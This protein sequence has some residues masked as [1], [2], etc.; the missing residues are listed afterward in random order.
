MAKRLLNISLSEKS[1]K[2]LRELQK[3]NAAER[4]KRMKPA[5]D[6]L[7][8]RVAGKI[9]QNNL[10]GQ[11]L[12]VRSG[13][14]RQSILGISFFGKTGLPGIEVGILKGPQVP[15]LAVHEF[16]TRGLVAGSPIPTIK[17]RR[18]KLLAQP[19][20]R[21]ALTPAGVAKYSSARSYPGTLKY[22]PFRKAQKKKSPVVAGLYD[23]RDLE[24]IEDQGDA[25]DL[26]EIEPVYLLRT[27]LDLP[28]R[29]PLENGMNAQIDD[30]VK[31]F[32]NA[33]AELFA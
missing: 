26:F 14:L 24:R 17:P 25:I 11:D 5:I 28:A 16:G 29:A 4:A 19:F 7:A 1:K 20:S 9:S 22:V 8:S 30:I 3:L 10:S 12:N 32:E 21:R 33:I 2:E 13:K 6:R 18:A 23:E 27:H 15:I 31:E